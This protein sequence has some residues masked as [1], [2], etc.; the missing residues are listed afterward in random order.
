[1]IG[2][3]VYGA[4]NKTA[5]KV[6][7]TLDKLPGLVKNAANTAAKA[8]NGRGQGALMAAPVPVASANNS[9]RVNN[10]LAKNVFNMANTKPDGNLPENMTPSDIQESSAQSLRNAAEEKEDPR[11]QELERSL[12]RDLEESAKEGDN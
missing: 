8:V 7:T 2:P 10:S 4:I 12:A 1:M 3:N 9:E 6:N 5:D 11:Q